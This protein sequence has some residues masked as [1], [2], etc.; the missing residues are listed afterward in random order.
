MPPQEKYSTSEE[1]ADDLKD[2]SPDGLSPSASSESGLPTSEKESSVKERKDEDSKRDDQQEQQPKDLDFDDLLPHVGEFGVYQK[3]LFVL[4]IPFAFFVAWV[5][6]SQ[7]FITLVPED[8]WC[9]VPELENL[10]VEERIALAIPSGEDGRSKCTM[11]DVNYTKLLSD[12]IR[13]VDL[14]WPTKSCSH[15]WEFNFTDIPYETVATELGWVCEHSALPTTAQSVFFIG[16][17]FG[18]LIFGWIADRYGRIPALVGANVT[19]FLAGVATVLAGSFW[20]FALCR[21]FVGFAFDNCFTMMYILVLEYV[22]PKWRTFVAN[23]SIALFFTFAACI[24]PWIAYF[25]ADWRMTCIA[26]SVPLALA[27]AAPW[28]VPESARWLVSQNRVEKAIE[29]LGKFERIN[30]TKVPEN[31]YKQFRETCAR[32]CKEQE[33]D[34]TYSVVDLFKSPRL[35]NITILL[36]IIWMAISLVFDGHV[37]NVN[38]LGLDVFMTFTVAAFTELPADTFL[39]LVLDRWGRRWL[40]CG[41]MVISGIFSI[42][43]C[44]VSNNIYSATLAIVGRFWVNISYNIGLQY[45]AEVLPTVV[46]AQGVALIHIMGYVASILAPFVVYL[47]VVSSILPLLLLGIIGVFGGLLTLFLPET[48]DKDLPQTLQD[49]ED[50]GKD[51]KMWDMPCLSKKKPVD[52]EMPPVVTIQRSFTRNSLRSS[53]RASTRGETLRSSMIQRSSIRSR[54]SVNAAMEAETK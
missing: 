41:T 20:E 48:L 45:A 24:L 35:R 33:A 7:I 46:R 8:H 22:G 25:L 4:M 44:A 16:A 31:V 1:A 3:I 10:T 36:I 37:R 28:L 27:I 21:F 6:F 2:A 34:K 50:F 14:K 43:A 9:R 29:I 13:D 38:N 5:Y 51:Q 40:A 52:A 49:G 18:G 39:T 53:M 26:I 12:G 23:M 42:W 30:G 47:D 11:Y 54:K 19:G 15:G 17:I 32:M